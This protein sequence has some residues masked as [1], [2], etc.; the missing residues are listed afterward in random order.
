M[1]GSAGETVIRCNVNVFTNAVIGTRCTTHHDSY[2]YSE[3]KEQAQ[4]QRALGQQQRAAAQN[5]S[6][7][8]WLPPG[9]AQMAAPGPVSS[10]EAQLAS[11]LGQVASLAGADGQTLSKGQI[12]RRKQQ[13]RYGMVDICLCQ[14][15][16]Y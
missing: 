5:G 1:L 14:F 13:L 8:L 15:G 12:R 10:Q 7:Q 2:L 16:R 11:A 6:Q 9:G 3:A 4:A